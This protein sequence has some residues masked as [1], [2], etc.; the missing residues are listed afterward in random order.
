[1]YLEDHF[2]FY[3]FPG[4][5]HSKIHKLSLDVDPLGKINI[6]TANKFRESSSVGYN[7]KLFPFPLISKRERYPRNS[8]MIFF[9]T[10]MSQMAHLA[11]LLLRLGTGSAAAALGAAFAAA[12]SAAAFARA[13]WRLFFGSSTGAAFSLGK[14]GLVSRQRYTGWAL[15]CWDS[16]TYTPVIQL[17]LEKDSPQTGNG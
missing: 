13:L 4:P 14:I 16:T 5:A 8:I 9:F 3:I 17:C 10:S 2:W 7:L 15:L 11:F 12:F 1:M 6:T